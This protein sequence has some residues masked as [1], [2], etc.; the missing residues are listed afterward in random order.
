M[1]VL[2]TGYGK[3][4]KKIHDL[5][6][7]E[8]IKVV[9]IIDHHNY[10]NISK[11]SD[12]DVDIAFEFT[13]PTS[14]FK[15]VTT[16][17]SQNIKVVSG[18]TGWVETKEELK[19]LLDKHDGTILWSSN[20]SIFMNI[21]FKFSND[22]AKLVNALN[23]SPKISIEEHHHKQKID[24]PSGTALSIIESIN[25]GVEEDLLTK[26][27]IISYRDEN[28]VGKHSLSLDFGNETISI[29]H[30]ARE[31]EIFAAGAI[32]AGKWLMDKK[33]FF[34]YSDFLSDITK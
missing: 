25:K 27:N 2:I 23:L 33:G 30:L 31:R 32:E 6:K 8:K 29:N 28:S 14:F 7:T 10:E 21:F 4:G 34:S 1:K 13:T 17:I 3:M 9:D 26:D 11:Y 5:C 15:N 20:F 12:K 18:T 19:S 24:V 22:L 16:L